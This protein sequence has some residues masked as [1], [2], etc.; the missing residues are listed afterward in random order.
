MFYAD[1]EPADVRP[2]DLGRT[3]VEV[4]RL[5]L[6]SWKFHRAA[7]AVQS[8]VD[9]HKG[10]RVDAAKESSNMLF[11]SARESAASAR[12][13]LDDI[14]ARVRYVN[15]ELEDA[16]QERLTAISKYV[17]TL[18]TKP[19]APDGTHPLLAEMLRAEPWDDL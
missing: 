19:A 6:E 15:S 8:S 16:L 14:I 17:A 18:R 11:G 12:S 5:M 1:R 9:V 2:T 13:I 3:L 7:L 4:D 10:D